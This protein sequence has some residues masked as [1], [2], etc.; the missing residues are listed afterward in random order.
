M[1]GDEGQGKYAVWGR[2]AQHRFDGRDGTVSLD[3]EVDSVLLGTDW[4]RGPAMAGLIVSHT[5]GDGGWKGE[6]DPGSV[7]SELLG[8]YPW[9]RYQ[10]SP[11]LSAWGMAG[12]G[13]GTLELTPEGQ[14]TMRT[15]L[16][17]VMVA[18]GLR[19]ELL[20]P[21]KSGGYALAI[22][23]D[24]LGVRTSTDRTA[25]LASAE[26][27]VTRVRLALEGS[28]AFS[29]ARGGVLT[30]G[31]ELGI[32]HDDGD[33]ETGF[34][35]DVGAGI[36][37]RNP[38]H[39]IRA[40]VRARG[41]LTHEASGF[42]E[43]GLSASLAWDPK[44]SSA[45]GPQLTLTQTLGGPATGGA[46]AL[47]ERTTLDGLARHSTPA[48]RR[49]ELKLGLPPCRRPALHGHPGTGPCV[50]ARS[51]RVPRPPGPWTWP[52]DARVRCSCSSMCAVQSPP[53]RTPRPSTPSVCA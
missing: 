39:G 27:D 47:L 5:K 37:W 36:A 32:R 40:E 2:A 30:P 41:L 51:P 11:R 35:A 42:R 21:S 53:V 4:M 12:Y 48:S 50:L 28:R 24:V 13:Q 29:F 26:A 16:D 10:L 6:S 46:Q 18:T 19:G 23:T 14:A 3:G 22:K 20:R 38:R 1:G 15:D 43:E 31:L 45:L 7:S 52:P 49:I 33:A 9:G 17:L 44:P 8:L 34:G 25:G